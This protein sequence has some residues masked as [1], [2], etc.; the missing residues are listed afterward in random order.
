M[1]FDYASTTPT[2]PLV[3]QA[4]T[5]YF[6]EK[7]GNA[8]SP[9][10]FGQEAS[11][12]LEASRENVARFLGAHPQE[13]IFNSGAT[14]GNNHA[15]SGI[16]Y[17]QM[18]KG[19]HIIVSAI[20]HHSVFEPIEHLRK[21]GFKVTVIGVDQWGQIDPQR[22]KD[23]IT[24]ETILIAALHASNE[25]GTIEPIKDIGH[26]ARQKHIPF[27]V[28]ACQTV[29]H[30]PININD[31]N[32]DCLS[33]S[34]HKFYGPKGMGALYVRKGTPIS[35]LLYGGDQERGFRA[36]TVNVAGAVGVAKAIELC[37]ASMDKDAKQQTMWRDYLIEHIT[38]NIAGV[39]INGHRQQRLPNNAH[40]SFEGVDGQMLLMQLDM[41]GIAASM[42]S[43]CTAGSLE[44][45]RV[46]KAIGLSDQLAKGSLRITLGRWT[47]QEDIDYLIEQLS[48]LIKRLR[49]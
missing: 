11:S 10:R 9:H 32:I 39:T 29:G 43:A 38:K 16:V 23:A 19:E 8:A 14:E 17:R 13:I 33:F 18:E 48:T 5:P 45:S 36:S 37:R 26:I 41:V 42:G 30:L 28:D 34:A 12:A 15:I 22:I 27:L 44:P 25:I 4:M 7:F 49:R 1:Y 31:L 35:P 3:I 2:D 47:K 6:F 24:S 21:D 20:E 46:L 40:F